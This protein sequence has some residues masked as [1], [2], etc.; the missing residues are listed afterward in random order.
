MKHHK[1][2]EMKHGW[3]V[4]SFVPTALSADE[5]EV[6]LKKY[7][8]GDFETSHHHKIAKEVTLIVEGRAIMFGHEFIAGD[9]IVLEPGESTSFEAITDTV[10]VVVKTPSVL[11]DKYID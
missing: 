5:F 2:S 7:K 3:F 8:A 1:I 10:T 4:G 6:A 9:I 11:G